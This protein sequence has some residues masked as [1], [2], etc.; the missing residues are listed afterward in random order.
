MLSVKVFIFRSPPYVFPIV[1]YDYCKYLHPILQDKEQDKSAT[2][3]CTELSAFSFSSG[4]NR[5]WVP[6]RGLSSFRA[7][8]CTP[9]P[10]C[11]PWGLG[12]HRL[13]Q[14][15]EGR[16]L[17]RQGCSPRPGKGALHCRVGSGHEGDDWGEWE[18]SPLVGTGVR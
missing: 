7:A 15:W 16:A 4:G 9:N 12:L 2:V 11:T 3:S 18:H 1:F 13:G 5:A 6:R 10:Q 14:A 8:P 17:E